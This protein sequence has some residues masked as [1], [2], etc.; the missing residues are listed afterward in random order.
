MRSPR[1]FFLIASLPVLF[2]AFLL[3]RIGTDPLADRIGEMTEQ[4]GGISVAERISIWNS[5]WKMIESR[6][7]VGVGVGAFRS[8]FPLHRE[9]ALIGK[10]DYAHNDYLESAAELGLVG[11]V[12]VLTVIVV[13]FR[14]SLRILSRR[15]DERV[16]FIC[17]GALVG[18]ASIL[19]HSLFDFNLR[20]PAN[21]LLFAYLAGLVTT[22]SRSSFSSGDVHPA[23]SRIHVPAGR[24]GFKV[25]AALGMAA[26][27]AFLAVQSYRIA[28]ADRHYRR[29][30]LF[31]NEIPA[32]DEE[33]LEYARQSKLASK[34]AASQT[35][36][37]LDFLKSRGEGE[38]PGNGGNLR[39]GARSVGRPWEKALVEYRKAILLDPRNASYWGGVGRSHLNLSKYV[40]GDS[41]AQRQEKKQDHLRLALKAFQEAEKRSP[42][43]ANYNLDSAWVYFYLHDKVNAVKEF[44]RAVENDPNNAH[45]LYEFGSFMI[46][47]D[48][49]ARG[50][51]LFRRAFE[52]DPPLFES[53]VR[54]LYGTV[55]NA[56]TASKAIPENPRLHVHFAR[57]LFDRKVAGWKDEFQKALAIGGN[58]DE[59]LSVYATCLVKSG[60]LEEAR[61]QIEK[62]APQERT[63]EIQLLQA[64][65]YVRTGETA[66]AEA[67]YS[68]LRT[69]SPCSEKIALKLAE[70]YA[71]S[72]S[73]NSAVQ[74]LTGFADHCSA[75]TALRFRRG[76]YLLAGG[77]PWRG[78]ED[79]QACVRSEP[80]NREYV[81]ALAGAYLEAREYEKAIEYYSLLADA[82]GRDV[83]RFYLKLAT[84]YE[85]LPDRKK[86]MEFYLKVLDLQ[87]SDEARRG[88]ERLLGR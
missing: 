2:G 83:P 87:D 45:L 27:C 39:D 5:T 67:I 43:A 40:L 28:E 11:F 18:L 6:P 77:F 78:V 3:F 24:G 35:E 74:V 50:L 61:A 64:D 47:N 53:K 82:G 72:R 12:L 75:S 14:G 19:I 88:V 85:Q 58:D 10:V 70:M 62:I 69:R 49:Q 17:Y 56:E 33:F 81:E 80:E 37:F 52:I 22:V 26:A 48:D 51:K 76:Q 46:H 55:G 68:G 20:V 25:G 31:F 29:A 42:R 16:R 54:E 8:V 1:T 63:E 13:F 73:W 21:G 36:Q 59:V 44:G 60:D 71:A 7:I 65:I 32:M 4:G 38:N 79:L 41:P 34:D 84:A 23:F 30:N 86:A 15:S 57:F 66:K 9:P